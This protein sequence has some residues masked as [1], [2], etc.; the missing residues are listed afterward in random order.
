MG[1]DRR[2]AAREWIAAGAVLVG[3]AAA[4]LGAAVAWASEGEQPIQAEGPTS[5]VGAT[6]APQQEQEPRPKAGARPRN[7]PRAQPKGADDEAGADPDA[8]PGGLRLPPQP[9][10]EAMEDAPADPLAPAARPGADRPA[11]GQVGNAGIVPAWPFVYELTLASVDGAPLAAR[12]FP[13]QEGSTAPILL[14]IHDIGPGRSSK[15]FDAAIDELGGK[16]IA[17]HLQEQGFAVLAIDLRGHGQS[18]TR[19]RAAGGG[20]GGGVDPLNRMVGDIQA[21]YRF[22]LDRHN[23]RELNLSKF[24]VVA[25]GEGANLVAAWAASPGGAVSIEGRTSDLAGLVLVSPRPTLG[26]RPIDPSISALAPRVP[27]LVQAGSGDAPSAELL[28]TLR[29]IVERQRLSRVTL[30]ETRL[31]ATNLL[32]FAPEATKPMVE[33]LDSVVKVRADEWEPRYNLNPVLFTNVRIVNLGAE[34]EAEAAP[35]AAPVPAPAPRRDDADAG[36]DEAVPGARREGQG[37]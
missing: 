9:G 24:G 19:S 37:S 31:P 5:V 20:G 32:R 11:A 18:P 22:L 17:G 6:L 23:R 26:E 15:D 21:G 16:G 7:I 28:D 29:P 35:D 25:L 13:S 10:A 30:T 33:F 8:E 3:V 2:R 36:A 27:M 1:T 14:M 4:T 12:Y 34:A